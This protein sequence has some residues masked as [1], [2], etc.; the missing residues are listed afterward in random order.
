MTHQ[1]LCTDP[2]CS[3]PADGE[4]GDYVGAQM[5][6]ANVGVPSVTVSKTGNGNVA[7]ADKLISCGNKCSATYNADAAVTLTAS[8]GSGTVFTGWGGSCNGTQSTCVL[9]VTEQLNVNATFTPLVN[10]SVSRS[11]SGSIS[12]AAA[13]IDCGKTCSS[14]VTQ[15]TT[16]IFSAIPAVGQHFV[17]WSGACSGTVPT[18]GLTINGDTKVQANFAK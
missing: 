15:G 9:S 5:A 7:S 17:N 14:R 6:A 18:C 4:I 16:A 10:V 13:G 8:A 11:G 12:A 2:A 3:V 1:A